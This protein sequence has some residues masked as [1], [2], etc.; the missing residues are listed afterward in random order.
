MV[1]MDGGVVKLRVERI[2]RLQKAVDEISAEAD[3]THKEF[4]GRRSALEQKL[5]QKEHYLDEMRKHQETRGAA[6]DWCNSKLAKI[7]WPLV[8]GAIAGWLTRGI[9]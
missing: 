6:E 1:G 5:D 7:F 2:D 9:L 3:E 4:Y 8:A